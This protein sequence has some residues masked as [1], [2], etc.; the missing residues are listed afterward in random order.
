MEKTMP[1]E[2]IS[3]AREL[4]RDQAELDRN[5]ALASSANVRSQGNELLLT[6][7]GGINAIAVGFVRGYGP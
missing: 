1:L 7:V 6:G 2:P 3:P 4:L 5:S